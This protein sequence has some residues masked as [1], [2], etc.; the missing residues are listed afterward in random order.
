MPKWKVT[1]TG[2]LREV[3]ENVTYFKVLSWNLLEELRKTTRDLSENSNPSGEK[4]NCRTISTRFRI[5]SLYI[6]MFSFPY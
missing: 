4:L 2:E 3:G 1:T 6:A 5:T